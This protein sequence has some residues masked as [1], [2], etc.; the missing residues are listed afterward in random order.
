MRTLLRDLCAGILAALSRSIVRKHKPMIVMVT[1][2]VGKTSTKDAVAAAL[3]GS[4][5]LR[6]SD[7]S[8]NSDFGVP[9]TIIGS[10]NPW[11]NPIAWISVFKHALAIIFLPTHY[12]KLLVL[13]VGADRPGDLAKIL[14]IARPDV[15]VVTLLPS[16]PVHVEAYET[17]AAVREE[18]FSPSL[19]LAPNAPLI[20]CADDEFAMAK[21]K[22]IEMQSYSYGV[23]KE[24][25]VRIEDMRAWIENEAVVGMQAVFEIGGKEYPVTIPSVLGR[26]SVFAPAAAVATAIA[27]GLTPTEALE[28]L[29]SYVPPPG[30][31][32]SSREKRILS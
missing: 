8:F 9:L 22:R 25:D 24:A 4:F 12:P 20:I 27:L 7:K 3:S 29:A 32:E 2:S 31:V 26:S 15:V 1:G 13:E 28:G 14:K 23:S 21:A 5:Y 30:E 16:V 18:E 19:V 11:A 10:K 17:P 6:K